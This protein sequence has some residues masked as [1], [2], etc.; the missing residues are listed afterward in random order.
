[1]SP[2]P[3][4]RPLGSESRAEI[5]SAARELFTLNGYQGTSLRSIARK[6]GVD[7][8][9]IGYFFGSKQELF[10]SVMQA[11]TGAPSL[12]APVEALSG[13]ELARHILQIQADPSARQV[14]IGLIR[15][16]ATEPMAARAL[17]DQI[18]E[19]IV[20]LTGDALD[21]PRGLRA[22]LMAAQVVGLF[23]AR[24]IVG[25]EPLIA[26]ADEGLARDLAPVFDHLL[27]GAIE[28]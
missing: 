22:S 7:P 11:P 27:S 21:E 28:T 18:L 24:Y 15:A 17:H 14:F 1:M 8:R 5:V 13:L 4:R 10:V 16:A 2:G 12:G 20:R 26:V 19:R 9:M 6:A 25:L 23:M 3:G